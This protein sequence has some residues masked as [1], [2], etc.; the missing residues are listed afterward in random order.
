[1][2]LEVR[3]AAHISWPVGLTVDHLDVVLVG[4][5]L[6]ALAGVVHLPA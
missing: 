1:M 6:A 5:V 3:E 4:A 2:A